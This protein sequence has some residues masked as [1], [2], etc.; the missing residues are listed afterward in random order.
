M[1]V[2]K[3]GEEGDSW[4]VVLTCTGFGN[5]SVG[6]GAEL[7]AKRGDLVY[8]A[9][10]DYPVYRPQAVSARCP[11]CGEVTDLP[12]KDWPPSPTRLPAFT[13]AWAKGES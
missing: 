7:R 5:G 2:L 1:E 11:E 13:N 9:G 3:K 10:T 12:S 6:C 8:Y 4:S